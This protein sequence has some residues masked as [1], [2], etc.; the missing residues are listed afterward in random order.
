M[1]TYTFVVRL[2]LK[3][4]RLQRETDER[5]AEEMHARFDH[6][7]NPMRELGDEMVINALV[8]TPSQMT[9]PQNKALMEAFNDVMRE[10]E[11]R[12]ADNLERLE[13]R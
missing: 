12:F 3:P 8:K 13:G 4:I 9:E 6:H 11:F 7:I 2:P 5:T 1:P 10:F